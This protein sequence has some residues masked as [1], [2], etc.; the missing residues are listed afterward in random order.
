L[1]AAAAA[2][3]VIGVPVKKRSKRG[4]KQLGAPFEVGG[5]SGRSSW[6]GSGDGGGGGM[7][8][9]IAPSGVAAGAAVFEGDFSN[10]A[11]QQRKNGGKDMIR[12]R[13]DVCV[14]WSFG[15]HGYH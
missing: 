15:T 5:R 12:G 8:E 7:L 13:S 4:G 9:A 6:H 1:A 11:Q 2:E 14:L 10:L 3:E